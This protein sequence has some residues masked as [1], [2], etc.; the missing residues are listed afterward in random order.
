M[1][2][3]YKDLLV[4]RSFIPSTAAMGRRRNR[5]GRRGS[6]GFGV[7]KT[8]TTDQWSGFGEGSATIAL[9]ISGSKTS[10][11][12]GKVISA[13]MQISSASPARAQLVLR[14]YAPEDELISS[15][16]IVAS[17]STVSVS[18]RAPAQSWWTANEESNKLAWLR[19]DTGPDTKVKWA[20]VVM[21]TFHKIPNNTLVP[22]GVT[23]ILEHN[24]E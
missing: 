18:V 24:R 13:R 19:V 1:G 14:G 20:Y 21:L 8:I 12:M 22:S 16:P 10:D 7:P 9:T 15:R 3:V 4:L 6:R 5:R 2:R 23:T 17:G 11:A